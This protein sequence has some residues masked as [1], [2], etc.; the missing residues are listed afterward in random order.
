M[1]PVREGRRVRTYAGLIIVPS[2]V[3]SGTVRYRDRLE[4]IVRQAEEFLELL[5]Q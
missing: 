1:R 3:L 2:V 4:E 5:L